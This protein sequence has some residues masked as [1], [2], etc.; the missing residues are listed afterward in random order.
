MA[1]SAGDEK[2][3]S[4]VAI[5]ERLDTTLVIRLPQESSVTIRRFASSID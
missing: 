3:Q 2:V 4:A 1:F 5:G